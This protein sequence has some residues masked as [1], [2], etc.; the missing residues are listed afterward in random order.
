MGFRE[1][2]ELLQNHASTYVLSR[3]EWIASLGLDRALSG[4]WT[5]RPTAF[6]AKLQNREDHAL[7]PSSDR[8]N[9]GFESKAALAFERRFPKGATLLINPTIL[10]ESFAFGG[11]NVQFEIEF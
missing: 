7:S 11:G 2:N 1:R 5:A 8:R 9:T 4:S 10:L 3:Q 6:L